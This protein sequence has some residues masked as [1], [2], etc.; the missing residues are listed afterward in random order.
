MPIVYPITNSPSP[1]M[2]EPRKLFV[3]IMVGDLTRS[4]A[5]F[6]ELGFT[7]NKQFMKTRC[8]RV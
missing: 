6:S 7:F 3:S 2:S 1:L 8:R 4:M 5:F